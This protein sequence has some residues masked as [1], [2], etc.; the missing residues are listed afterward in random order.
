MGEIHFPP[1]S[2]TSDTPIPVCFTYGEPL[3]VSFAD[4]GYLS[5]NN[6]HAFEP[7]LPTGNFVAPP[8]F[9]LGPYYAVTENC[10]VMVSFFDTV[11]GKTYRYEITIKA[12]CP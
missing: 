12:S 10:T 1:S 5:H 6:P 7:N 3:T 9:K 11:T 4:M 2:E 8:P